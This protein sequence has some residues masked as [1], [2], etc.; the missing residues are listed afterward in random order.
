MYPLGRDGPTPGALLPPGHG[1]RTDPSS[2]IAG[3]YQEEMITAVLEL[4]CADR[5]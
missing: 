4:E 2:S 3:Y 1:G 5:S